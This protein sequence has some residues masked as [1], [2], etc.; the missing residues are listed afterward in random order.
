MSVLAKL[1]KYSNNKHNG[2]SPKHDYVTN[3]C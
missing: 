2:Y 3:T 1:I